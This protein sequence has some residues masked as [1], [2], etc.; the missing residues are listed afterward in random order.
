VDPRKVN[1]PVV[2]TA[3]TI[4]RHLREIDVGSVEIPM[5][6]LFQYF[7]RAIEDHRGMPRTLM[8]RLGLTEPQISAFEWVG[9]VMMRSAVAAAKESASSAGNTIA[10]SNGG[11]PPHRGGGLVGDRLAR[12]RDPVPCC[13]SFRECCAGRPGLRS[14]VSLLAAAGLV[15]TGT[16]LDEVA[17]WLTTWSAQQN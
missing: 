5:D 13:T 11:D 6:T 1:I 4:G 8:R 2:P 15:L 12:H 9:A 3:D 7:D 16:L 10:G 14:A 17:E